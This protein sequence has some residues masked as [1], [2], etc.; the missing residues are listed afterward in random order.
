M[1]SFSHANENQKYSLFLKNRGFSDKTHV[2]I[3][4]FPCKKTCRTGESF[5]SCT[6]YINIY[7]QKKVITSKI[8][9]IRLPKNFGICKGATTEEISFP[10]EKVN[11]RFLARSPSPETNGYLKLINYRSQTL[12]TSKPR[13]QSS[14]ETR[15]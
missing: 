4:S 15:I 11:F 9:G 13:S 10:H 14:G 8:F 3:L 2:I 5:R 6:L 1:P 12:R 7:C